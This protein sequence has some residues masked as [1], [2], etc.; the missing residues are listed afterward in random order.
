MSTQIAIIAIEVVVNS[1]SRLVKVHIG[2][3]SQI[4]MCLLQPPP[5]QQRLAAV[6]TKVA[7]AIVAA[8]QSHQKDQAVAQVPRE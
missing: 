4:I 6:M 1:M 2:H 7:I 8:D 5:S 3:L